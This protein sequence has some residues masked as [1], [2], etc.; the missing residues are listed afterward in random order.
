MTYAAA[1]GYDAIELSPL[2]P[3][4]AVPVLTG[5]DLANILSTVR[6]FEC[7]SDPTVGMAL[8]CARRRKKTAERKSV[9]R[10]CTNQRV[11]RFPM[12]QN[13]AY[14]SHFKLFSLVTAGRDSGSFSFEISALEEHIRCYLSLISNLM[15]IDFAFEEISVELSDTRVVSHLCAEFGIDMA[16]VRSGV[17]ARDSKSSAKVL[18]AYPNLWPGKTTQPA[19]D[20]A[21]YNL[22]KHLIMQLVLLQEKISPLSE[23]FPDVHIDFNLHRLTGL[24]YYQG[25]CFHIKA[26]NDRGEMFMLGDGGFVDWTQQLLTDGKERLMTSAIGTELVIRMFGKTKKTVT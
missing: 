17:R 12:P 9:I 19:E 25:P 3:F 22:P 15:A 7:A 14:T 21:Q 11:V 5:L 16:A 10:L 2:N 13:P 6:A 24:G 4:G 26:K 23:K 20:L 1:A 18:E 8:E